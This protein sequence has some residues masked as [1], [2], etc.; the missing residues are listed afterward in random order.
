M[1]EHFTADYILAGRVLL[2]KGNIPRELLHMKDD[3]ILLLYSEDKI[4][5]LLICNY[6]GL[7]NEAR[8]SAYG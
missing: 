3:V 6:T 4:M 7:R 8:G 1:L 2:H 5:K